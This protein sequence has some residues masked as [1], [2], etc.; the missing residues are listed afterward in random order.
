[1]YGSAGNNSV[2]RS[3]SGGSPGSWFNITTTG[4]PVGS[5][6]KSSLAVDAA[7]ALY[8]GP[9]AGGL[10]KSTDQGVH[11]TA[12]AVRELVNAIAI[13]PFTA[14]RV[15]AAAQVNSQDAFLMKIV[16]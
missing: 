7:Q 13:D 4:L 2:F 12:L 1:V 9:T 15:Y 8:Y 11:W 10:F 3:D 5:F 6:G 16:E 14:G